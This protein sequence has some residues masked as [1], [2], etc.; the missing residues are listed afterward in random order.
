[1]AIR[2]PSGGADSVSSTAYPHSRFYAVRVF[3]LSVGLMLSD[4]I[5]RQVLNATFPALKAEWALSDTQL[6]ALVS[7]V[8]LAVGMLSFPVSLMVDRW[9]RIRSV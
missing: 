6:G 3:V 1:M 8:A 7:V 9:G 2:L 5:S 4:Y